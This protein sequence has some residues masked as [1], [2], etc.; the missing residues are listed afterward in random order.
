MDFFPKYGRFENVFV[1]E[2][3]LKKIKNFE[4]CG[5]DNSKTKSHTILS[6]DKVYND[7]RLII[8]FF[9]RIIRMVFHS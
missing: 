7:F 6:R 1:M 8:N 9:L 4:H 3:D 5:H 2:V